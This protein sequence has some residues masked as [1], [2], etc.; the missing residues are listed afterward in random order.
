VGVN[1]FVSTDQGS[2]KL[3]VEPQDA[4]TAAKQINSLAEVKRRRDTKKVAASLTGLRVVA[5]TQE[6]LMPAILDAVKAY[7]TV[8]EI[9]HELREVFGE[10]HEPSM[11][12]GRI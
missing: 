6:N 2:A 10:Y 8:G 5:S 11:F 1:K 3:L 7:A 9:V 4:G 12:G